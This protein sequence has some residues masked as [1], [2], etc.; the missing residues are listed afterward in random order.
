MKNQNEHWSEEVKTHPVKDQ[1]IFSESVRNIVRY[2]SDPRVSPRG[3]GQAI[4]KLVFYVNRAGTH[5]NPAHIHKVRD[6]IT[7]LKGMEHRQRQSSKKN[8]G[9]HEAKASVSSPCGSS[10]PSSHWQVLS[11][12]IRG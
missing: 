9:E 1:N 2:F 4:E 5:G 12:R 8:S 3:I 7:I 10:V 11:R 6:A